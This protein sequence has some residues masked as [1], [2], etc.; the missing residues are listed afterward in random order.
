[1]KALESLVKTEI[2]VPPPI[3]AP[4]LAPFPLFQHSSTCHTHQDYKQHLEKCDP[5]TFMEGCMVSLRKEGAK[6]VKKDGKAPGTV[7]GLGVVRSCPKPVSR[8]L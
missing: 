5:F 1:M 4:G 7:T 6:G 2:L 8:R 3:L